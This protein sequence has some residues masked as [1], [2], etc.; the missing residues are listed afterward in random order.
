MI[1]N[2]A[3]HMNFSEDIFGLAQTFKKSD[4]KRNLYKV[5]LHYFAYTGV[6]Q[7]DRRFLLLPMHRFLVNRNTMLSSWGS[8]KHSTICVGKDLQR[9][10]SLTSCLGKAYIRFLSA[11]PSLLMIISD[12]E[13]SQ[14]LGIFLLCCLTTLVVQKVLPYFQSEF[15]KT[16]FCPLS[17]TFPIREESNQI[18]EEAEIV[19]TILLFFQLDKPVFYNFSVLHPLMLMAFH[20]PHCR[21][22]FLLSGVQDQVQYPR[23]GLTNARCQSFLLK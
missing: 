21:R 12:Y 17:L 4:K 7:N 1:F 15:P 22:L 20:R 13:E 9:S 14:P 8:Q 10:L 6:R 3:K 2:I 11:L 5:Q 19:P 18:A 23:C 16:N